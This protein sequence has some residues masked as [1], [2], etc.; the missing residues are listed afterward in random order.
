MT[1][2]QILTSNSTAP[3]GSTAWIHLNNQAGDSVGDVTIYGELVTFLLDDFEVVLEDDIIV[4]L[5]SEYEVS[6]EDDIKVEIE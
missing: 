5:D 3:V 1:A 6:L 2:W 4:V